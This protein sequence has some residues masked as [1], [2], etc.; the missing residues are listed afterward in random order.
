[1]KVLGPWSTRDFIHRQ[2]KSVKVWDQERVQLDLCLWRL[3]Q[4]QIY[5]G[6][7]P[8]GKVGGC[9]YLQGTEKKRRAFGGER[10]EARGMGGESGE[11]RAPGAVEKEM[12]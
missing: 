9:T 4:R 1:M 10:G 11:S 3:I 7:N 6:K 8:E 2:W 5:G 12:G